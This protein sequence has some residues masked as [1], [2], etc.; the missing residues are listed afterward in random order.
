MAAQKRPGWDIVP[1]RGG[2]HRSCG[3]Q[4]FDH[5][6]HSQNSTF[7]QTISAWLKALPAARFAPAGLRRT[8][9]IGG[10]K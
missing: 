8:R 10:A 3:Q 6:D 4:H 2:D 1:A 9:Q 5:R 7:L